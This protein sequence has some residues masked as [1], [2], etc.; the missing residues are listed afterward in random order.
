MSNCFLLSDLHGIRMGV[1]TV[2]HARK[3]GVGGVG[4]ELGKDSSPLK[5]LQP[6]TKTHI[7]LIVM[8]VNLTTSGII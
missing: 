4:I 6:K 2:I 3:G 7:C 8:V 5:D 1:V